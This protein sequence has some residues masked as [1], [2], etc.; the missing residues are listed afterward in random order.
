MKQVLFRTPESAP[1]TPGV[2]GTKAGLKSRATCD[3]AAAIVW[4]VSQ[5][6]GFAPTFADGYRLD[7]WSFFNDNGAA[8]R[9]R[10]ITPVILKKDGDQYRNAPDVEMYL[11]EGKPRYFGAWSIMGKADWAD[12]VNLGDN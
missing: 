1:P 6:S 10:V 3:S 9:E 5:L 11:V 7:N 8:Q 12:W 2:V 4:V